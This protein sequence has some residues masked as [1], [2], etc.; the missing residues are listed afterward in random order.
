MNT[1]EMEIEANSNYD[2]TLAPRKTQWQFGFAGLY[3]SKIEVPRGGHALLLPFHFNDGKNN[4]KP[5]SQPDIWKTVG[6]APEER[7]VCVDGSIYPTYHRKRMQ[8]NHEIVE[9]NKRIQG[10][11]YIHEY[12]RMSDVV[13]KYNP[14]IVDYDGMRG[15]E[16]EKDE[17]AK[18]IE[19]LNTLPHDCMF[20]G[21]CSMRVGA[22]RFVDFKAPKGNLH[23]A[24]KGCTETKGRFWR[25]V[26][27]FRP[28]PDY[29]WEVVL[30][31]FEYVADKKC[32]P[33]G[34]F[35]L[36]KREKMTRSKIQKNAAIKAVMTRKGIA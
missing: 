20:L 15:I 33:M 36:Y 13:K 21:N 6:V 24:L 29:T 10:H 19:H 5:F 27:L 1:N 22:G 34:T 35:V 4:V 16:Q 14:Y 3:K 7:T 17:M 31:D 23:W 2:A 8:E 25:A 30:K 12:G 28:T 11:R 9:S 26:N 32:T 18:I